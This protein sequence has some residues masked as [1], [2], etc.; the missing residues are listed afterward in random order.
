MK[1][2]WKMNAFTGPEVMR[3]DPAATAILEG[4]RKQFRANLSTKTLNA[5]EFGFWHMLGKNGWKLTIE[6]WV[7]RGVRLSSDEGFE[8]HRAENTEQR[9]LDTKR[10]VG[11]D[12]LTPRE[13]DVAMAAYTAGWIH[14]EMI[15]YRDKAGAAGRPQRVTVQDVEAAC[16]RFKAA[17]GNGRST[18]TKERLGK[19]PYWIHQHKLTW[20]KYRGWKAWRATKSP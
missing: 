3:T 8:K 16:Q 1:P 13:L 20:Q 14:A 4:N 5:A 12:L 11:V 19:S 7:R 15:A 6:G 10:A 18:P 2:K 9:A 17:K